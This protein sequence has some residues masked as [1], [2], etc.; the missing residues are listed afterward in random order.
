MAHGKAQAGAH[1]EAWTMR[2]GSLVPRSVAWPF[3]DGRR[4]SRPPARPRPPDL[5]PTRPSALPSLTC[6]AQQQ[7][8][9]GSWVKGI[10]E[11][12]RGRQTTGG[13]AGAGRQRAGR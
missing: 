4:R 7:C 11:A 5:P 6:L 3:S 13:R 1:A 2:P 8:G 9:R 10:G 12:A